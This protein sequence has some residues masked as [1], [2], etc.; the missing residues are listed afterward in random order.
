MYCPENT[1]TT[2]WHSG[3]SLMLW[4]LFLAR[5]VKLVRVEENQF[6]SAQDWRLG[7]KFTFQQDNIP[8]YTAK[9]ILEWLKQRTQ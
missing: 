3:G 9:A 5:I 8:M 4:M 7:W 6:Q 2:V 1:S